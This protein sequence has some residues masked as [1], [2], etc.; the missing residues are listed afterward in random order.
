VV[1][2]TLT[3]SPIGCTPKQRKTL[4]ALGLRKIR[5]VREHND[6]PVLQGMLATVHHLIEV[7]KQ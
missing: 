2:I 6:S 4:E 5:Q 1:R 3:K 7:E